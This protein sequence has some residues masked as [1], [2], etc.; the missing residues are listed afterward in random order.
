MCERLGA[1]T[2][3]W[4]SL[5]SG[6]HRMKIFFLFCPQRI[7]CPSL[8]QTCLFYPHAVN[9]LYLILSSSCLLWSFISF[10]FPFLLPSPFS[11]LASR[12]C[13]FK[14]KKK[15]IGDRRMARV[16]SAALLALAVSLCWCMGDG[17]VYDVYKSRFAGYTFPR[18]CVCPLRFFLIH[19]LCC[20]LLNTFGVCVTLMHW[21]F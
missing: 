2:W 10:F 12:A 4:S 14:G 7:S 18:S 3:Q 11:C 8:P 6:M 20:W 1:V 13:H 9:S 17:M 15:H 19:K 5:D 21:I 16:M